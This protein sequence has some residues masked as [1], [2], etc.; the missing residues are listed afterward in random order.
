MS[1]FTCKLATAG[2]LGVLLTAVALAA[3]EK[4]PGDPKTAPAKQDWSGYVF[5]STVT[6]T[7]YRPNKDGILVK[8]PKPRGA[9]DRLQLP[10]HDMT[11]VRWK[12]LPPKLD[13]KGKKVAR[14][15][16]EM[17]EL[18]LPTGAPGYAA[19]RSDLEAAQTVEVTMMRPKD[20]PLNKV[21]FQDLVVKQIVITGVDNAA[22]KELQKKPPEKKKK[23]K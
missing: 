23:D 7:I 3:G 19:A 9:S 1:R 13:E 10:F 12:T 18:K 6:G 2:A 17:K 16:A 8:V 15:A 5:H 22:L 21:D 14:S 20:I 11:L 4:K